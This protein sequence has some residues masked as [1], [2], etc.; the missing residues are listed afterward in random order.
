M[1]NDLIFLQFNI[2]LDD[3]ANIVKQN[4]IEVRH[5]L[6]ILLSE[7]AKITVLRLAHIE[8]IAYSKIKFEA[9]TFF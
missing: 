6:S 8:V 4:E 3:L 2:F 9:Y 5:S 1:T 7:K